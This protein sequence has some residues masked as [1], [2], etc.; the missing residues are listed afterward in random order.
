MTAE[1]SV[2]IF[3]GMTEFGLIAK[4]WHMRIMGIDARNV[5]R[6]I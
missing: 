4:L 2:I 5:Q 3:L 1:R 6:E